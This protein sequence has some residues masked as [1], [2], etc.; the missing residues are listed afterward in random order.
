M[1]G[2]QGP[3]KRYAVTLGQSAGKPGHDRPG[4]LCFSLGAGPTPKA[5]LRLPRGGGGG[6]G[7]G[8]LKGGGG[9]GRWGVC[10]VMNHIPAEEEVQDFGLAI[11]LEGGALAVD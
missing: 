10:R 4:I 3:L 6:E 9:W 11:A 1:A 7:G 2:R 8:V 5:L